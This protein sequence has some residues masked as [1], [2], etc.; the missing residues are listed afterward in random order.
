MHWLSVSHARSYCL[1]TLPGSSIQPSKK[2]TFC[3]LSPVRERREWH[4]ASPKENRLWQKIGLYNSYLPF[5]VPIELSQWSV[6]HCS[7]IQNIRTD[8]LFP[9]RAG[10][11][12]RAKRKSRTYGKE[13]SVRKD[14]RDWQFGCLASMTSGIPKHQSG[15]FMFPAGHGKTNTLPMLFRGY[16]PRNIKITTNLPK[17]DDGALHETMSGKNT[18]GRRT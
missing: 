12:F 5:Y 3:P 10:R 6:A 9:V 18:I 17:N 1:P 16:L 8:I 7:L 4:L 2:L 13:T 15:P 11:V 14:L